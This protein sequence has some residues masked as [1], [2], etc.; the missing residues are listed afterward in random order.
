MQL[1]LASRPAELRDTAWSGPERSAITP[2]PPPS[3]P[4]FPHPHPPPPPLCVDLAPKRLV[5][6]ID[7][8]LATTTLKRCSARARRARRR[9][10]LRSWPGARVMAP[11][12]ETIRP[13][14]RTAPR[15]AAPSRSELPNGV[16]AASLP[17]ANKRTSAPA[18]RPHGCNAAEN[19]IPA[20]CRTGSVQ[21]IG[22][23]VAARLTLT[24]PPRR[25]E[26][27]PT[28]T[29]ELVAIWSES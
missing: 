9:H 14:A 28:E 13:C 8:S 18:T 20:R 16:N 17:G 21:R 10:R 11:Q 22:A 27:A 5:S 12:P 6:E 15:P 7:G 25:P 4:F 1:A 29:H 26:R 24:E 23:H 2:P 19:T 3:F